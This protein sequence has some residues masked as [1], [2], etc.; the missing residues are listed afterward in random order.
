MTDSARNAPFTPGPWYVSG[1]LIRSENAGPGFAVARVRNGPGM[2]DGPNDHFKANRCLIAA[3][4]E[5]Y[6]LLAGMREHGM[7][8]KK[9]EAVLAKARGETIKAN[10]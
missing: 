2:Y 9:I 10:D 5:M 1:Q 6:D 7:N 4:P 3:A 8:P